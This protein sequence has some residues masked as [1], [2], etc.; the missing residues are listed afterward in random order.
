MTEN[1]TST[2]RLVRCR[3]RVVWGRPRPEDV[4]W[5]TK[6]GVEGE[7]EMLSRIAGS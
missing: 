2:T 3:R 1:D 7:G 6:R 4:Q 5:E